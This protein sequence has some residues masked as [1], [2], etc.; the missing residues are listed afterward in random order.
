MK[1][2]QQYAWPGNVRELRNICERAAVLAPRREIGAEMLEPWLMSP[3]EQIPQLAQASH[4]APPITPTVIIERQTAL[5]ALPVRPLEE[6]ERDQ[7]VRT[8]DHFHGNRARTARAL[9]IGVRTLGLKL[10]KWKAEDLIP[11]SA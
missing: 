7:I 3:S 11:Q 6:V 8:L 2:L 5:G 9:G 4:A 10:K 1:L